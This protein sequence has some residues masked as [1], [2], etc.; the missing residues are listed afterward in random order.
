MSG[1]RWLSASGTDSGSQVVSCES[2]EFVLSAGAECNLD[3]SWALTYS[4]PTSLQSYASQCFRSD[5]PGNQDDPHQPSAYVACCPLPGAG[6]SVTSLTDDPDYISADDGPQD[7][8]AAAVVGST[9][10]A[11][12]YFDR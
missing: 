9:L 1:C 6:A 8:T 10:P 2:T 12:P 7:N 4:R 11:L 5:K 3:G